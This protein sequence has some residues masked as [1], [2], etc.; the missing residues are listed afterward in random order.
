[1]RRRTGLSTDT[2]GT[3]ESAVGF[4]GE[5]RQ[6]AIEVAKKARDKAVETGERGDAA[7]AERA[8]V[9]P[10]ELNPPAPPRLLA[11]DRSAFKGRTKA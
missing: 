1:M 11:E 7:A 10:A 5:N 2:C 9:A 4:R 3:R 8:A 6:S